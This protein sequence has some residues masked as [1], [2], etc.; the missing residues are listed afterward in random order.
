MT[1]KTLKYIHDLLVES[2]RKTNETYKAARELQHD[3][4]EHSE[5]QELIK[6]QTKA[7]DNYMHE[8]LITVNALNDFEAQEW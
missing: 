8:H 3:Y 1:I 5:N 2:E 4:E 6:S 7:A